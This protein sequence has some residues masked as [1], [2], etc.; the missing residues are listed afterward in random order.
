MFYQNSNDLVKHASAKS[1]HVQNSK[2]TR[3]V[4]T[5]SQSNVLKDNNKRVSFDDDITT[6][7][8]N[9]S[10]SIGLQFQNMIQNL[11]SSSLLEGLT[12]DGEKVVP[13]SSSS[14]GGGGGGRNN[15]QTAYV[16]SMAADNDKYTQQELDHIGKV[17]GIINLIEKND[18]NTRNQWVEVSDAAGI[19]KYGYITSDG[20]FQI[21]HAPTSSSANPSNWLKTD[22]I[23][24]NIG[25]IG[26]PA[27]SSS[28]Q[29]I[30]IAG[31]WNK[32]RPYELI[33]ADTDSSRLNP[34]FILINDSVRD[35]KNSVDR[36]GLFSCGNERGNVYVG[37]RP[38]ADFDLNDQ[39][40]KVGCYLI[41][42]GITDSHLKN[43]QF[44][45]QEDLREAS[46]SQCKRRAE[47]LGSSCF[48]ISAPDTDTDIDKPK[49]K[50]GC[51][52]YTGHGQPYL[53]GILIFD[54]N[55]D[56]CHA[57][58]N[59]EPD[60]DGFLKSYTI[61]NLKRLYGK[62]TEVKL[63]E[64]RTKR[65]EEAIMYG[66]WIGSDNQ[67]EIKFLDN[68]QAV[69]MFYDGYYTKMVSEDNQEKYYAGNLSQFNPANWNSYASTGGGKYLLRKT[70]KYKDINIGVPSKQTKIQRAVALYYLKTGGPTGVDSANPNRRGLVGSIAYIDHNGERHAYPESALSYTKPASYITLNGY[71]TRSAESSYG[72]K[73]AK[74]R[75]KFP[76]LATMPNWEMN[77]QFTLNGGSGWRPLIGNMYNNTNRR[78]WGVWVSP[79]KIIHWSWKYNTVDFEF[80]V[81]NGIRYNLKIINS[82]ATLTIVLRNI[83]K[84]TEQKGASNKTQNDVMATD[85]PV[86]I[87]GWNNNRDQ[88]QKFPGKIHSISI[89][90]LYSI[91]NPDMNGADVPLSNPT[92]VNESVDGTFEKCSKICDDDANCGG[93]VYTKPTVGGGTDGKCE[94]KDRTKMFPV[95]LRVKDPTKQLMIKV[96]TINGTISDEKCK[97]N[98][99]AYK[100]I[101]SAQYRHY[102]DKGAMTSSSKCDIRSLIPKDGDLEPI[103]FTS[104]FGAVDEVFE[105]TNSKTAEYRAQTAVTSASNA[106]A[107]GFRGMREGMDVNSNY[108][109]TMQGVGDDLKKIANAEYQRERLLAITEE[110]NKLLMAETY[111]FILWSVLAIL[112]VLAL[113]KLK[114]M[115]GQDESDGGGGEG[116]GG[117]GGLLATILGWFGVG[118]MKLDDVQD[119]TEDAKAALSAAGDQLREAGA[120]LSTGITEGADNLVNS[121]TDAATGAI[122]GANNLVDKAKETASGAIDQIGAPSPTTGGKRSVKT[123]TRL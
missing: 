51:W 20:V 102:P 13:V 101:D 65:V 57:M 100:I 66:S 111:K 61:S 121:A 53:D 28:T 72:L 9:P 8:L 12:G 120:N 10:L 122:E 14:G 98:N 48:F 113:L 22:T 52:V 5:A 90:K 73:D 79:S 25:V 69:Y 68:G 30:K 38:T 95:G 23:K 45:F 81:D 6:S 44:T 21:W 110:T 29:K 33:Y 86:T 112:A 109:T 91:D 54:E 16:N 80:N 77:I 2:E 116:E 46:I 40:I 50:G 82:P 74:I 119:R 104:M 58:T 105:E 35:P 94:L 39:N 49:N 123:K 32:I 31:T 84:G 93:F 67:T 89:P 78:G 115:F 70:G 76:P 27:Q 97:V 15:D 118:S 55:A 59:P 99:G 117:G 71:D 114:E 103:D 56:K 1:G 63:I 42:E 106:A 75:N 19:T 3:E 83:E 18:K 24:Q 47:D 60:E 26:C 92:P 41:P 37:E 17:K 4:I 43:R 107:E 34:L 64:Q 108:A 62:N 36:R 96:P 88:N 87:G 7:S 11:F 85:G